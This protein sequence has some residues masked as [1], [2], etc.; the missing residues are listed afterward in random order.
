MG[1]KLD[2]NNYMYVCPVCRAGVLITTMTI[3]HYTENDAIYRRRMCGHCGQIF[4][5]EQIGDKPEKVINLAGKSTKVKCNHFV[6]DYKYKD[7]Y[8]DTKE[9]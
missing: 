1:K 7:N 5:T 3:S 6:I 2:K 4:V 9:F 8:D